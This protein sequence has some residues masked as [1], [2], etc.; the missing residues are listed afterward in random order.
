MGGRRLLVRVARRYRRRRRADFPPFRERG[1]KWGGAFCLD[2]C[3][4]QLISGVKWFRVCK[5]RRWVG[6]SSSSSSMHGWLLEP[7]PT[8]K[9]RRGKRGVSASIPASSSSSALSGPP[10]VLSPLGTTTPLKG[11]TDSLQQQRGLADDQPL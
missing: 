10:T 7:P 1:K 11:E 4:K 8:R 3:S 9:N 5:G 6:V 2:L